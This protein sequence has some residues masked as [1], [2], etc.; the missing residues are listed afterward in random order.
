MYATHSSVSRSG[1]GEGGYGGSR[2]NRDKKPSLC[3]SD[4]RTRNEK[5]G[6]LE[7]GI[8]SLVLLPHPDTCKLLFFVA[9]FR[10]ILT[11][12]CFKSHFVII[13]DT[14][15]IKSNNGMSKEIFSLQMQLFLKVS[16][17]TT[18]GWTVHWRLNASVNQLRHFFY[19]R[20]VQ[21]SVHTRTFVQSRA[22]THIQPLA[23]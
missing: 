11:W 22:C 21:F 20:F 5:L 7:F 19:P 9:A 10:L 15:E 16:D 4:R 13:S 12:K 17:I 18:E 3:F 8:N 23:R 14:P 2:Q 6:W 1:G